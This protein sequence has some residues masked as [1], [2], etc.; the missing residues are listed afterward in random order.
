M[1][2][3]EMKTKVCPILMI[4]ATYTIFKCETGEQID[5]AAATGRCQ[6][7]DCAAWVATDNEC[8]PV[9]PRGSDARMPESYPAGHCGLIK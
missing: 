5:K 9:K 7:S 4:V 2:E 6:G 1:K 8:D 3:S